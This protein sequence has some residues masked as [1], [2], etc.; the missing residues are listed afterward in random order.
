MWIRSMYW[1]L[2]ENNLSWGWDLSEFTFMI[3]FNF[4][5]HNIY[6][7]G[8]ERLVVSMQETRNQSIR[9]SFCKLTLSALVLA[10]HRPGRY[11]VYNLNIFQFSMQQKCGVT[12]QGFPHKSKQVPSKTWKLVSIFGLVNRIKSSLLDLKLLEKKLKRWCNCKPRRCK[13]WKNSTRM[14]SE[15]FKG[16][17]STVMGPIPTFPTFPILGCTLFWPMYHTAT[18]FYLI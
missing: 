4:T 11:T 9:M 13:L 17:S 1:Q 10:P 2:E 16:Y 15:P 12:S 8:K 5:H 18:H 7:K 6:S 3:E 14:S